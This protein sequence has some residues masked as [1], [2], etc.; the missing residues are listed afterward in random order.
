[1]DL[2]RDHRAD[3]GHTGK[4]ISLG[5]PGNY[6]GSPRGAGRGGW[7]EECLGVPTEIAAPVTQTKTKPNPDK[8]LQKFRSKEKEEE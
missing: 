5:L 7:G 3:P 1:M 4:I 6:S 2:G 8:Q